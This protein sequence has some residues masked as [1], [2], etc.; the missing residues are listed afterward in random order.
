MCVKA[1][2]ANSISFSA[3]CSFYVFFFS[4]SHL[5]A[6]SDIY[7]G[8]TFKHHL[9]FRTL[10]IWW[11]LVAFTSKVILSLAYKQKRTYH[12]LILVYPRR[13]PKEALI[14][15][16]IFTGHICIDLGCINL[17]LKELPTQALTHLGSYIFLWNS[18]FHIY[19][20]HLWM[21]FAIR[22]DTMISFADCMFPL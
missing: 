13:G 5:A 20:V 6:T 7:Q 19:R 8:D 15:L 2:W 3:S 10:L 14:F 1:R 4:L 21:L 16:L 11:L 17:Y 12:S 18:A 22:F 9:R